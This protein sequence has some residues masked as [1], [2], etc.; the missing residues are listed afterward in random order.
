MY[1]YVYDLKFWTHRVQE[2][3][4]LEQHQIM[5]VDHY[6]FQFRQLYVL[7]YFWLKLIT[8]LHLH[9]VLKLWSYTWF[10]KDFP[11]IT[12]LTL[13]ISCITWLYGQAL[14]E[15]PFFAH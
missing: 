12:Y 10:K 13:S 2:K 11:Y 8:N 4:S 7:K 6:G 5:Q 15:I 3:K 14:P 1:E 9:T